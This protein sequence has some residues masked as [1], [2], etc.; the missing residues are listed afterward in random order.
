VVNAH[1]RISNLSTRVDQLAADVAAID[2]GSSNSSL[3]YKGLWNANT[4]NPTLTSGGGGGVKNDFYIVSDAGSTLIDGVNT[5]NVGDWIIHNGSIWERVQQ[6]AAPVTSVNAKTGD[7]VITAADVGLGNVTN[8]SKTTMFNNPTFTGTVTMD[9][10]VA[11]VQQYTDP[12]GTT[13]I[14]ASDGKSINTVNHAAASSV[15]LPISP[16]NGTEYRI[17]NYGTGAVSIVS[18]A[19]NILD[20]IGVAASTTLPNYLDKLTLIYVDNIWNIMM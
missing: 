7:V 12:D 3:N 15:L 13:H 2:T 9:N 11:G 19:P 16:P 5:W 17:I 20:T 8:E 4:N 1:W 18:Q 6:A 14:L 10:L